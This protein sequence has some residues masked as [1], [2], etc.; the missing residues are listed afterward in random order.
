[1]DQHREVAT[2]RSLLLQFQFLDQIGEKLVICCHPLGK[3]G[4]APVVQDEACFLEGS[5]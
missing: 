3:I 4:C 1:M 5:S 2:G